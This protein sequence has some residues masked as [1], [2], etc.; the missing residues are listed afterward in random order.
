HLL[1]ALPR[2]EQALSRALSLIVAG[3]GP[4]RARPEGPAPRPGGRGGV[5]GAGGGGGGPPA[6]RGGRM[7]PGS[8]PVGPALRAGWEWAGLGGAAGGGVRNGGHPRLVAAWRI[9]RTGAGGQTDR[10]QP[11]RGPDAGTGRPRPLQPLA[12]WSLAVSAALYGGPARRSPDA[13][14]GARGR[15]AG[16]IAQKQYVR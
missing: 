5:V 11:R 8:R 13:N 10:G 6:A 3:D 14:P 16:M 2:A 4:Q 7:P 12:T 9:G 15:R 1:R